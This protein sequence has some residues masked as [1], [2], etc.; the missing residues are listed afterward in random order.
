MGDFPMMQ[1]FTQLIQAQQQAQGMGQSLN[2]QQTQS[3][4]QGTA[5][6]AGYY[7]NGTQQLASGNGTFNAPGYGSAPT[8]STMGGLSN[9]ATDSIM[10]TLYGSR[11]GH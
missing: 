6:A 2:P 10:S 9:N 8:T 4:V 1:H 5:P 3:Y 11:S 7:G